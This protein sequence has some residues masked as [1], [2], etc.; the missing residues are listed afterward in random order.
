M[1]TPTSPPRPPSKRRKR[2]IGAAG[3]AGGTATLAGLAAA[4]GPWTTAAA[5]PADLPDL[6]DNT[7]PGGP[8]PPAGT[9]PAR[10]GQPGANLQRT[11][12]AAAQQATRP[13]I[14]CRRR[15]QHTY[16]DLQSPGG[17]ASTRSA[18]NRRGRASWGKQKSTPSPGPAAAVE[19]NRHRRRPGNTTRPRHRPPPRPP[20]SRRKRRIG[21][22]GWAGGGLQPWPG[23]RR[24]GT[25]DDCR[26]QPGRPTRD[27]T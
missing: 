13:V 3:W 9:D 8:R 7:A 25:V 10:S 15:P 2:R 26:C 17:P 4:Q 16:K 20:S 14:R 22:A 6:P 5:S 11:G 12:P 23:W 18:R 21:A 19:D 1:T 27:S 24:P